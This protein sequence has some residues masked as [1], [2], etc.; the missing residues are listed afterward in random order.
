MS[1]SYLIIKKGMVVDMV[2]MG[3]LVG[4]KK[5]NSCNLWLFW[6]FWNKVIPSPTTY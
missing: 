4:G 3:D 5:G 6:A 1:G 2:V